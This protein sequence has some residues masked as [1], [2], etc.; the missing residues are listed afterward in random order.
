MVLLRMVARCGNTPLPSACAPLPCA[1]LTPQARALRFTSARMI[2]ACTPSMSFEIG[3]YP[4]LN[5]EY[6]SR[7]FLMFYPLA[8]TNQIPT[9]GSKL[10][11]Q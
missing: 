1:Y 2:T 8:R 6:F 7:P 4:Y 5:V 11:R 9:R 3:H 10:L